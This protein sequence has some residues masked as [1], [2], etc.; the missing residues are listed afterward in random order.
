MGENPFRTYDPSAGKTDRMTAH[1][2]RL[3]QS[4]VEAGCASAR[5]RY[6]ALPQKVARV[7]FAYELQGFIASE[8]EMGAS[9]EEAITR[10]M[11]LIDLLNKANRPGA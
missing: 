8:V 2:E 10:L 1:E 5:D 3:Q 6:L 4:E 7:F 9:F 11:E